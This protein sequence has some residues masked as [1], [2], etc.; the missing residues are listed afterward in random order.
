VAHASA[1]D[2]RQSD[3]RSG[4]NARGHMVYG[5]APQRCYGRVMFGRVLFALVWLIIAA[6]VALPLYPR[7]LPTSTVAVTTDPVQLAAGTDAFGRV[8]CPAPDGGRA[9]CRS[10]CRC[11]EA[12]PAVFVPLEEPIGV[13]IAVTVR[14]QASEPPARLPAKLPAI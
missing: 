4:S 5:A 13:T 14:P 7:D 10:D 12:Q 9:D 11:G 6:G 2:A 1:I 3:R 8:D